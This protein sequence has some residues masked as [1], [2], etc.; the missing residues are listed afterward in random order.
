MGRKKCC[1]KP[2][3]CDVCTG[4]VSTADF[5]LQAVVE[6]ATIDEDNPFYNGTYPCDT[7]TF[8]DC[9]KNPFGDE[10]C[11][12]PDGPPFYGAEAPCCKRLGQT[13]PLTAGYGGLCDTGFFDDPDEYGNYLDGWH[14]IE[15]V[16]CVSGSDYRPCG[17]GGIIGEVDDDGNPMF[18]AWWGFCVSL[19]RLYTDDESWKLGLGAVCNNLYDGNG[20]WQILELD[21]KKIDCEAISWELPKDEWTHWDGVEGY[22]YCDFTTITVENVE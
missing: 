9:D 8:P 13:L 18:G 22:G 3:C 7:V 12:H 16:P 5:D 17:W 21:D 1:C 20:G 6:E 10:Y 15:F 19:I 14:K 11:Y 2:I 4:G